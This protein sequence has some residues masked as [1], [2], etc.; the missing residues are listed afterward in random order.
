MLHIPLERCPMAA[1]STEHLLSHADW[2]QAHAGPRFSRYR[3]QEPIH[4][5]V[6]SASFL[7]LLIVTAILFLRPAEIFPDLEGLKIYKRSIGI[8]LLCAFPALRKYMRWRILRQQPVTICVLAL[9]VAAVLSHLVHFNLFE[10]FYT[11]K[12]YSKIIL[13]YLLIVTVVNTPKRFKIMLFVVAVVGSITVACCVLDYV[14]FH[15]FEFIVHLVDRD[16]TVDSEGVAKKILRMRGTGLFQDPNDLSMV[17]VFITILCTYF[18]N[19]RSLK[20]LRFAWLVPMVIMG[21][22][23]VYTHSRGGLL[24][25]G[26]AILTLIAL[27]MGR[28]TSIAVGVMGILTLPILLG[29]QANIDLEGG[30]GGHRVQI[31]Q[32]GINELIGPEILFG[33]GQNLYSEISGYVAHNSYVHTYVELGLFGGTWFFGVIFFILLGFYRMIHIGTV[34]E[35][36]EFKRAGSYVVAGLIGWCVSMTSLSRAYIAPTYMVFGVAA[37]YLNIASTTMKN[38]KVFIVFNSRTLRILCAASITFFVLMY[39]FIRYLNR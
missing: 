1:S 33:I 27:R 15:D 7:M 17:I 2:V 36:K 37:A 12:E 13:Y 20:L 32:D 19:Q 38:P 31:W 14:H 21:Y 25:A 22:G 23:L 30:T 34:L 24:A 10:L 35:D 26:G 39:V 4:F 3:R 5:T 29:R 28:K 8:A 11:L 18:L 9:F 6:S 16:D